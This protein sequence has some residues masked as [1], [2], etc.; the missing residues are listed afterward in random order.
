MLETW[1][2]DNTAGRPAVGVKGL[3]VILS[4]VLFSHVGCYFGNRLTTCV[5]NLEMSGNLTAI[6]KSTVL[7]TVSESA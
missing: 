7:T 1:A 3:T 6:S 4:I 2:L 5:E